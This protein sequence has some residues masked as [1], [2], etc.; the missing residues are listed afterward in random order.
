MV[1]FNPE[2][3]SCI[4][5]K[6]PNDFPEYIAANNTLKQVVR[7]IKHIGELIGYNHV[8]IGSDYNGIDGTPAGLEDVSKFPALIAELL[9]EGISD[10][11]V[12]KIAGGNLLRVWKEAD[13]VAKEL[14]KHMLP[15]EDEVK[16][17]W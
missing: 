7:H 2:F 11:D 8:G 10:E 1:N 9:R 5:G 13:E 4:P 14:Q 6:T 15:L 17:A 12:A 16:D 3:V